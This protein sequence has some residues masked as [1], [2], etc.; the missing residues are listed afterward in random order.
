MPSMVLMLCRE[1]KE[2][3]TPPRP[4]RDDH[5]RSCLLYPSARLMPRGLPAYVS[6]PLHI[7]VPQ[8]LVGHYSRA[9]PRQAKPGGGC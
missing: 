6:E 4:E 5:V 1:R 9:V 2:E 7:D 3:S 8:F